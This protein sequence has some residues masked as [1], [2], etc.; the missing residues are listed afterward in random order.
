MTVTSVVSKVGPEAG[1]GSN[2]T[3]SFSPMV[4]YV[5]SEIEV[6]HVV[7]ATGVETLLAIGTG[8]TTYSVSTI[9]VLTGSTGSITYPA[10]ESTPIPSTEAIVIKKVLTLEQQTDLKSQGAYS[11]SVLERQFDKIVGMII[12]INETLSRCIKIQITE[13]TIINTELSS[14]ALP[15]SSE[16]L[17]VNSGGTSFETAGLSSG[18]AATASDATPADVNL[19]AGSAGSGTD[20]SRNDHA[21]LLPSTVPTLAAANVFTESQTWTKGSDVGDGDIAAGLLTL[22]AGNW[23]D[24]AGTEDLDGIV[25]IGIG[26]LIII[27]CDSARKFTHSADLVLPG[28]EDFYSQAGDDL[29]FYEHASADWRLVAHSAGVAVRLAQSVDPG[30]KSTFYDDFIGTIST[31]ISST[32]GSGTGNAAATISAGQGGRVTLTSANDIAGHSNEVSTITLDT[33]DWL[34]SSGGLVA[35]CRLQMNTITD[36]AI[37]FGFTDAI[38][39]TVNL[40]VFKTS[41]ADTLDSDAAN[42]CGIGFD[43]QGSTDQWWHGGVKAGTDTAAVHSGSA[44]SNGTYVT[45]RVEVDSSGGVRG[46]I[47]GTAIGAATANAITTGAPITPCLMI[48]NRTTSARILTI[49]YIHCQ[50]HR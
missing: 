25:S 45:L 6:Y 34:A 18:T 29:M 5:A 21:H 11:P 40:P 2:F 44:P 33:L 42:A 43:T 19:S 48:A 22:G 38:S 3:F 47:D 37:F 15:G 17:R 16:V 35:E 1:D 12:Q 8:A 9:D 28:S 4:I 39:S 30:R 10:D 36:V 46:Y 7:T 14:D 50:A 32:A 41:A 27:H 24:L 20:F 49:D 26:T 31:P 23:F 13:S